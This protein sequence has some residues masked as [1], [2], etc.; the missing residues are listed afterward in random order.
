M[1]GYSNKKKRLNKSGHAQSQNFMNLNG[2]KTQN[3]KGFSTSPK[4]KKEKI[5]ID[6][7][8][9][10]IYWTVSSG[11]LLDKMNSRCF[12]SKKHKLC[13]VGGKKYVISKEI[14]NYT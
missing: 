4:A 13:L 12:Y 9:Q 11:K 14:I 8:S 5:K 6:N 10:N 2:G 7:T 3:Y 1:K